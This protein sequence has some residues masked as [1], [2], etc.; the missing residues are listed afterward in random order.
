MIPIQIYGDFMK[1]Y[2]KYLFI[3]YALSLVI[4]ITRVFSKTETLSF[5]EHVYFFIATGA[6]VGSFAYV[7]KIFRDFVMPDAMMSSGALDTFK[8]K[9]FWMIGPQVIAGIIGLFATHGLH[10]TLFLDKPSPAPAYGRHDYQ[11]ENNPAMNAEIDPSTLTEE[12]N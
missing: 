4:T 2:T 1:T 8:Q 3:A 12:K 6:F 5:L 10:K 9:V 11:S 7:G